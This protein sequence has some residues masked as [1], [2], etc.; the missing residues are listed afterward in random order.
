MFRFSFL[1][2]YLISREVLLAVPGDHA[3][4]GPQVDVGRTLGPDHE[5]HGEREGGECGRS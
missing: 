3:Q 4:P 2:K 1:H 5:G